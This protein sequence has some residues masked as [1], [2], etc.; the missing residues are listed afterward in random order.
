[1]RGR[2]RTTQPCLI[3]RTQPDDWF[4]PTSHQRTLT[5]P[6]VVEALERYP[7]ARARAC[8]QQ[9]PT[10]SGLMK[11]MRRITSRWSS[12]SAKRTVPLPS[13]VAL[14]S[15]S[16]LPHSG[17]RARA[18]ARMRSECAIGFLSG[19]CRPRGRESVRWS[20]V[21]WPWDDSA[22]APSSVDGCTHSIGDGCGA[23]REALHGRADEPGRRKR[24]AG[25]RSARVRGGVST[26]MRSE[27]CGGWTVTRGLYISQW[28]G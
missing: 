2:R 9:D 10:G 21:V 27:W 19:A 6:P 11:R 15:E 12:G 7:L 18:R 22:N 28:A 14:L 4:G 26:P 25:K 3:G 13:L 5:D 23:Q 20:S 17:S 16:T 1:M 24:A 8:A